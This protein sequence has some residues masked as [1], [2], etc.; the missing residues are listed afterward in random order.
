MRDPNVNGSRAKE[1]M[2][3]LVVVAAW[4]FAAFIV[5]LLLIWANEIF[6]FAA[7]VY[8]R[9]PVAP[10]FFGASLL[11]AFTILSAIVT[12]GQTYVKQQRILAGFIT[13]CANCHKVRIRKNVWQAI[14]KYVS[15]YCPVEFSHGLCPDCFAEQMNAL[16]T[17]SGDGGDTADP[18]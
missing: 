12:V 15:S 17:N 14:E 5:L 9:D 11:S 10:D 6:D 13:V 3:G 2:H 7:L 1:T 18:T 16:R 4:Q 8:G